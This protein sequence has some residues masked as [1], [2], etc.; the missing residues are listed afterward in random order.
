M[1]GDRKYGIILFSEMSTEVESV[2]I[3]SIS[4]VRHTISSASED[5]VIIKWDGETP[6]A[7]STLASFS[8]PYTHSQIKDIITPVDPAIGNDWNEPVGEEES[9]P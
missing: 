6:A 9:D 3:E 4:T 8:G 2:V 7:V 5:K 1:I